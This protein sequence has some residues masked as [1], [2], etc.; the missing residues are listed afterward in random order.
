M[1]LTGSVRAANGVLTTHGRLGGSARE[2][3]G[4]GGN[5]RPGKFHRATQLPAGY[6]PA[7][8]RPNQLGNSQVDVRSYLVTPPVVRVGGGDLRD[9]RLEILTAEAG[10][11]SKHPPG[12]SRGLLGWKR[13]EKRSVIARLQKHSGN[14]GS[15]IPNGRLASPLSIRSSTPAKK[16]LAPENGQAVYP[17]AID[18]QRSDNYRADNRQACRLRNRG[19]KADSIAIEETYSHNSVAINSTWNCCA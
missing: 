15:L 8:S 14:D 2:T 6:L 16:R 4:A 1:G 13:R 3:L 10:L 18:N 12:S 9:I 19:H 5:Q 11:R 7:F 17:M